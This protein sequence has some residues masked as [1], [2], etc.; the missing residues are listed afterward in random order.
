MTLSIQKLS[1][2]LLAEAIRVNSLRNL[3]LDR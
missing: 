2:L 1:K 3:R